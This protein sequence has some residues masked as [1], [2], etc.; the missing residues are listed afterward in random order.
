MSQ[1]FST[2]TD[3][4]PSVSINVLEGERAMVKDNHHLGMFD[5]T[6]IPPAPRGEPQIEVTFQMDADGILRVSAEDKGTGNVEKIT[7]KNDDNRLSK[8]DI[9][10]MV[11]DAE[12]FASEDQRAKEKVEARNELEGYAYS[13]K[14]QV[15]DEEKL[16]GKLSDEDKESIQ[17]AVDR[18]LA[19]LEDNSDAE[20]DECEEQKKLLEKVVHPIVSK[21]YPEGGGDP[22]PEEDDYDKDEL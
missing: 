15:N 20:K 4:Q 18:A 6:G 21:V 7:I 12:K 5:L 8:E 1:I 13:L 10:R 14:N 19:W 2:A 16:G 11:N 9:D 17:T 3:N 22:A